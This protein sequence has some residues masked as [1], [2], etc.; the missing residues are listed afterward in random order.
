MGEYKIT[1]TWGSNG[2][3]F[4]QGTPLVLKDQQLEQTKKAGKEG[5]LGL[6]PGSTPKLI[7]P[8]GL[9]GSRGS[10]PTPFSF[11]Q[12]SLLAGSDQEL[13]K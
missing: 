2:V 6:F 12:I 13:K 4:A 11:C 1:S 9:N 5:L 3:V 7:K 10:G 8:P